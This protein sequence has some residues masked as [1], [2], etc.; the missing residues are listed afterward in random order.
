MEKCTFCNKELDDLKIMIQ[1]NINVD[2]KRVD[3]TWE[4]VPNMNIVT[5]ET[6]CQSCFDKFSITLNQEMVNLKNKESVK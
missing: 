5:K 4:H 1:L 2:R 3:K 6:L